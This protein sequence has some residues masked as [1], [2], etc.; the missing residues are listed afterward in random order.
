M[1]GV[2]DDLILQQKEELAA[3]IYEYRD[4]FSSGPTDM[5]RTGLVK[6]TI[7]TGDQRPIRLPPHGLPIT[8]QEVE[9]EEVQK[10][11]DRGVIEPCQSSWASPVI[12]VT[13]K[14]GTTRFCVDYRKLNDETRK[15]AYPLPRIDNTLDALRGSQYFSTLDLYS[16][17]WQVEIDE[18]DIDKT[19]FVTRQGLFRFTVMPF[20]LC[21]APATY[22]RLMELVLK[23]LNWKVCLIYLDDIIMYRA[24]FYPA[25][26]RLKMVWKS[27]R[28]ANLKLKPTKCCLMRAQVPF[29]GH[30]VSREGVGVD[31]AKTEAVEKWP[32]P[33][34]VKDVRAFLGLA[35][36]YRR[37]IPGISTMAAP[38]TNLTRQGV[39]LVWDD[40]CD[41]AF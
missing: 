36:H 26:D 30:I 33:V 11:L 9:K 23:H 20:G 19:A 3:A 5:G 15:D 10:M 7:D 35:S 32:T 2:A 4:V 31:P 21:N 22:Q 24:G 37:Y 40:A 34:N 17:Y 12:L 39:D 38:M 18:Q 1:E 29:L 41:G 8:K 28:E 6:H 25:L 13:K 14:D 16:G 27:I